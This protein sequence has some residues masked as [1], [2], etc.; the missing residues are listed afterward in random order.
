MIF[1]VGSLVTTVVI[2]LDFDIKIP[3]GSL[4]MLSREKISTKKYSSEDTVGETWFIVAI[5]LPEIGLLAGL[6]F[7]WKGKKKAWTIVLM[8]ICFS[9][10]GYILLA[11]I[12]A[13]LLN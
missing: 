11:I 8:S 2:V 12:S 9:I 10:V 6:Y 1:N 4:K 3:E 13:R 5:L 7:A